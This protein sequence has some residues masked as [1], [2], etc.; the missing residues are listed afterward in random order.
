MPRITAE[1]FGARLAGLRAQAEKR[2]DDLLVGVVDLLK[3]VFLE[4]VPK[5]DP[6]GKKKR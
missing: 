4:P 5:E 2:E 6:K 3:D 1:E